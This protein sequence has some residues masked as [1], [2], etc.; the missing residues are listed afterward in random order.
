MMRIDKVLAHTGY[1][2]RKQVRQM[3]KDGRVSVNGEIIRNHGFQVNPYED[4]ISAFG[5]EVYYR[6]YYYFLLNK[7][8]GIISATEDHIHETVIDWL[9]PDFAYMELFPVGRLDIDTTG[10][11][12]LTNNGPLSHRLLSPKQEVSKVYSAL[13]TGEVT[14]SDIDAFAKGLDLG[15]FVTQPSTLTAEEYS[16]DHDLSLTEVVITE[17]KFHQVKRMF[18]AVGKTVVQLQRVQMGPLTLSE[19]LATGEF[20]EL[21]DEEKESLREYGL[22][23]K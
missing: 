12:L 16:P 8:E 1:G 20:R 11:L 15:D 22:I 3:I 14:Q 4:E 17:G 13:V 2:T 18:E 23:D 5:E 7:P 9:G 6:K 10:L 21:T 19:D